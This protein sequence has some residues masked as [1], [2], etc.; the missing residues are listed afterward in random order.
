[1][2]QSR[3][4]ELSKPTYSPRNARRKAVIELMLILAAGGFAAWCVCKL[5]EIA[6]NFW[7]RG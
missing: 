3:I 4:L 2:T 6:S 1:M 5:I 7:G